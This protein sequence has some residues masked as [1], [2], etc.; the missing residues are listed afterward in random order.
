MTSTA[1]LLAMDRMSKRFG[2]VQALDEV[3]LEARSG[4]VLAL[5]GENGA[6]KSTLMNV[7]GGMVSAESGT[8]TIGGEAYAPTN[9]RD[10]QAAGISFI[11]QELTLSPSLTVAENI[12][13]S[14]YP[15]LL[16][17]VDHR[18]IEHDAAE[19]L[20]RLGV[21]VDARS[22]V[23]DLSIGDQQLVEI[24]RALSNDVRLI[25]FDEPTSSLTVAERELLFTVIRG[26]RDAG[27]A[28]IYIS[29]FMNEIFED[30]RP[31]QCHAR[32][33]QRGHR[34]H[35]RGQPRRGHPHDGRA[36]TRQ[37]AQPLHATR[38]G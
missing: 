19:I 27:T 33:P 38:R 37:H 23:R 2:G 34:G 24:A 7:L 6:G 15:K 31:H 26:L 3:S 22:P 9:P 17:L 10:A 29:H 30:L 14:N 4:E 12:Y 32:R 28:V 1:P 25:I 16:G 20:E 13:I 5:V 35:R 18:R 11:H 21:H 8:M 36:R